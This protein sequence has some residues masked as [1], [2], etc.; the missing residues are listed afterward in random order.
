MKT[1]EIK[2]GDI[3][4]S[5]TWLIDGLII[6]SIEVADGVGLMINGKIYDDAEYEDF[7]RI[8]ITLEKHEE[9]LKKT[10]EGH[11]RKEEIRK[12]QRKWNKEGVVD[13][14]MEIELSKL[15]KTK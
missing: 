2:I 12:W 8:G 11:I 4:I 13:T 1:E 9:L 6:E 7:E 15:L 14:D 5:E 10:R 3:V